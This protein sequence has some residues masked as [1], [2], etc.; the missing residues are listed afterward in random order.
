MLD[1]LRRRVDEEEQEEEDQADC[2]AALGETEPHMKEFEVDCDG[3]KLIMLSKR[4][5]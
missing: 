5:W 2:E 3:K 1:E 4:G